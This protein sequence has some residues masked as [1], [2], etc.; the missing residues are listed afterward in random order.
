MQYNKRFVTVPAG[1]FGA[2]RG[3]NPQNVPIN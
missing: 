1:G 3:M 2:K